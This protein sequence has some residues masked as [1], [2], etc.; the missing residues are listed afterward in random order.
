MVTPALSRGRSLALPWPGRQPSLNNQ[1]RSNSDK[2]WNPGH[3]DA[4]CPTLDAHL[5]HPS[6]RVPY[7]RPRSLHGHPRLPGAPDVQ[8]QPQVLAGVPPNGGAHPRTLSL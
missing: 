6:L 4:L 3:V 2:P 8:R 7:T 5:L 1:S